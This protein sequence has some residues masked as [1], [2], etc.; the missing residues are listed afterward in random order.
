MFRCSL[1]F[2][3]KTVALIARK[4]RTGEAAEGVC[5]MGENVTGSIFTFV[6]I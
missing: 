6:F 2:T 4:A 1:T 3:M 5:T